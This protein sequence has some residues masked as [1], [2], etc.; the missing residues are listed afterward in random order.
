MADVNVNVNE[1]IDVAEYS[2]QTTFLI[3]AFDSVDV[4]ESISNFRSLA[5]LPE[6]MLLPF[7]ETLVFN[8]E[9]LQSHNRTEQRIAL[10]RGI[11]DRIFSVRLAFETDKEIARFENKIH[12]W[13]KLSWAFPLWPLAETHT[14]TITAGDTSITLDT[15]QAG[16]EVNGF[17]MIWSDKDTY[18]IVSIR[19]ITATTLTLTK[20]PD[21]THTGTKYIMPCL[22]SRCISTSRM[23]WIQDRALMKMTFR[24]ERVSD[25][26]DYSMG[27]YYDN[28]VVIKDPPISMGNNID[29]TYNPDFAVLDA[30]TGLFDMVS[31]SD[32]NIVTQPYTWHCESKA[33]SWELRQMF[34]YIN[35]QQKALLVPTF[36]NDLELSRSVGAADTEIYVDNIGITD[37]MGLN[38]IRTYIAFRPSGSDIIVRKVTAITYIS[39]NEEM[40]TID[41]A[42]GDT[43]SASDNLCWVDMCRLSNDSVSFEWYQRGKCFVRSVL[44]RIITYSDPIIEPHVYDNVEATDYADGDIELGASVNDNIAVTEDETVSVV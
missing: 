44:T 19:K 43:F 33:E 28:H 17:A 8:N 13:L 25:V 4:S 22:S 38:D 24:I 29:F 9:I 21:N 35:G 36:R 39:P 41:A 23:N 20:T 12:R 2:N 42:T 7:R 34:H 31:N 11:P 10:R 26:L 40:I 18:D 3:R 16:Y 30:G 6:K 1:L 32:Y 14:D 27:M 37:D 5:Y 15:T